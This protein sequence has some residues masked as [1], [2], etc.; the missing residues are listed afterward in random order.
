MHVSVLYEER[1]YYKINWEFSMTACTTDKTM[2]Q[3]QYFH[4]KFVTGELV[5]ARPT[6]SQGQKG[7]GRNGAFQS[8]DSI[9]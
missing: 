5:V 7:P 1:S 9:L 3:S 4:N 2:I 8:G 6:Q